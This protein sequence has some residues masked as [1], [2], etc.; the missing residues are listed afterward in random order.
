MKINPLIKD[1]D[2]R[3]NNNYYNIIYYV[4][5]FTVTKINFN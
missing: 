4:F 1:I 2:V 3:K 5:S